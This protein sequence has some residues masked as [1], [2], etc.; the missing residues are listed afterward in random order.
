MLLESAFLLLVEEH[1]IRWLTQTAQ[2]E[3]VAHGGLARYSRI[4]KEW[5]G[6][7]IC[8]QGNIGNSHGNAEP[9]A[10]HVPAKKKTTCRKAT[11]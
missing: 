9:A 10:P 5:N 3:L 8:R 1:P 2:N 11:L 4:R 6:S 7:S